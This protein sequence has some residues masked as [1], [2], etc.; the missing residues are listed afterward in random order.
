MRWMCL[1][2][3]LIACGDKDGEGISED[4]YRDE[5]QAACEVADCGDF[6]CDESTEAPD[7]C[8]F[9]PLAAEACVSKA[10]TCSELDGFGYPD[11]PAACADVYRCG[12]TTD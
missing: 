9:D 6:P 12:S 5:A 1:L 11:G 2:G 4:T 7:N 3:A 8:V 10:W